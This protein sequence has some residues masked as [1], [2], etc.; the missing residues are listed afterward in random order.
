MP[1]AVTS[2]TPV[3]LTVLTAEGLDGVRAAISHGAGIVCR[4]DSLSLYEVGISDGLGEPF[5]RGAPAGVVGAQ[6]E[7]L[8]V[9]KAAKSGRTA[10]TLDRFSDEREQASVDDYRRRYGLCLVRALHAFGQPVGLL[11]LHFT[12][13]TAL[14]EREFD[15]LRR[16]ADFAAIALSN[17]RTRAELQEFAYSD[18]L[19]GLAN[20]RR[21][22]VEFMRLDAQPASLML[23]DFDGLKAV[24]DTLGY[25]RGDILIQAIGTRLA[26]AA[27]NGE[28][29]VRFGGDEFVVILPGATRSDVL[30]RAQEISETLDFV[31]LPADIAHLFRGASVGSATA[32]AGQDLWEVLRRANDEM[33]SRKRRRKTDRDLLSQKESDVPFDYRSDDVTP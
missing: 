17:A 31:D 15:A 12:D 26:A 11:A 29:V 6:I 18:A 5:R 28:F 32:E 27:K 21:L 19:T 2:L 1:E 3:F 7:S 33:R 24:N 16:F 14:A 4:Y 25:D 13:R 22:E 9:E 10:S 30:K 20:R 23:I 8:L